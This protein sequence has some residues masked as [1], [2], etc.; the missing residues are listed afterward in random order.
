GTASAPRTPSKSTIPLEGTRESPIALL[1]EEDSKG[2]LKR[3]AP[4]S[5]ATA[6]SDAPAKKKRKVTDAQPLSEKLEASIEALKLEIAKESFEVKGKFPPALKPP[7]QQLAIQAI[8][9]GEYNESFFLRMP[10]LFPYNKFTMTKLIKRL[11]YNDHQNLL[12][13]R[14]DELLAKLKILADQGFE[15]AKAEWE[16]NVQNWKER[17]ARQQPSEEAVVCLISY[18]NSCQFIHT[19]PSL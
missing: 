18:H 5:A 12:V 11:V 4:A 6:P 1:D 10:Q 2:S 9:L 16:R 14:Q 15:Q 7:L 19:L 17:M 8:A 13:A 3:S